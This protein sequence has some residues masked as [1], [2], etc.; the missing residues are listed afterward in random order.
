MDPSRFK[1]MKMEA[2]QI[3][4]LIG[5]GGETVQEIRRN[6]GSEAPSNL[7]R[8]AFGPENALNHGENDGF[9]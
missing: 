1:V 2:V 9:R 5:R 7:D 3:R 4:A 6:S 8:A